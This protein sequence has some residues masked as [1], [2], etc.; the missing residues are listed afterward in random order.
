M[1]KMAFE[2]DDAAEAEFY[3][4]V[5]HY[6]QHDKSLSYD[7]IQEFDNA[8]QHLIR[9]P[10]AGHPYLHETKRVFL[11]RFPYAIVYK[12]YHDELIMVFAIMH[13]KRKPDYW[14]K[15]LQ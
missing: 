2:L 14:E 3:G 6:K 5:D 8:V 12:I 15:R 7:F 11:N 9:F 13:L 10:N 1:G 4:I